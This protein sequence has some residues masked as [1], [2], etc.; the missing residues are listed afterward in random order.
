MLFLN[1]N[2]KCDNNI[3]KKNN[4]QTKDYIKNNKGIIIRLLSNKYSK[5]E[6]SYFHK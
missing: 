4:I 2:N 6:Y 1:N 5:Y 3:S